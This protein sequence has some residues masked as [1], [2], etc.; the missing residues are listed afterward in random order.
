MYTHHYV[1]KKS[2]TNY[3]LVEE[4]LSDQQTD[5][6]TSLAGRAPKEKADMLTSLAGREPK[7]SSCKAFSHILRPTL[8]VH[9]T[10]ASTFVFA[11]RTLSRE[12]DVSVENP[13]EEA[14]RRGFHRTTKETWISESM[15]APSPRLPGRPVAVIDG[16]SSRAVGNRDKSKRRW[17][18]S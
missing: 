1:D 10:R 3:C 11:P 18:R 5:M 14:E 12:P 16:N 9:S 2:T 6:L 15:A 8:D 4:T 17:R 7:E 13:E